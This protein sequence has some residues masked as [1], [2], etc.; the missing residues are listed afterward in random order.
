MKKNLEKN[1]AL[2]E[3]LMHD[4]ISH[5][6]CGCKLRFLLSFNGKF[7]NRLNSYFESSKIA[8]K[9]SRERRKTKTNMAAEANSREN[10][11]FHKFE[12]KNNE[13]K[14]RN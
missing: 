8:K 12:L 6:E 2:S 13:T 9:E 11:N 7:S 4:E 10:K 1:I 3:A 5:P 14:E